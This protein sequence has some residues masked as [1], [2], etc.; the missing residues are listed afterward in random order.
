MF[1][2]IPLDPG[3]RL[4]QLV[5]REV[6]VTL[7]D[8]GTAQGAMVHQA[9]EGVL[10]DLGQ[11]GHCAK[12]AAGV[13]ACE[14]QWLQAAR[15]GTGHGGGADLGNDPARF[16]N[17]AIWMLA[18][19]HKPAQ[20]EVPV[21]ATLEDGQQSIGDRQLQRVAVLGLIDPEITAAQADPIPCQ[22]EYLGA[23]QPGKQGHVEGVADGGGGIVTPVNS[24]LPDLLYR[25]KPASELVGADP[26][27]SP[28]G[29]V[30]QTL[31][32]QYLGGWLGQQDPV[33]GIP[34]VIAGIAPHRPQ[35]PRPAVSLGFAAL[36]GASFAKLA[37]DPMP[38]TRLPLGDG[39]VPHL[40]LVPG[41]FEQGDRQPV[42]GVVGEVGAVVLD[43]TGSDTFTPAFQVSLKGLAQ[44]DFQLVLVTAQHVGILAGEAHLTQYLQCLGSGHVDGQGWVAAQSRP[45]KPALFLLCYAER[46]EPA[47]PNPDAEPLHNGIVVFNLL[48][49]GCRGQGI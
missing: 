28:R 45:D 42:P 33:V 4:A 34:V 17:R 14:F 26:V 2:N 9:L 46:L 31:A 40:D 7:G 47:G 20:F 23:A 35:G 49:F 18:G 36:A 1:Q 24:V 11:F 19:E 43:G 22:F 25:V 38:R 21:P 10:P 5:R 15:V 29:V 48:A 8:V 37:G 6:D 44:G 13:M 32:A 27:G 41:E 39:P 12:G 30:P 16:L 3:C